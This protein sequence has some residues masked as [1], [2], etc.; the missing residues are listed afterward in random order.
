M[1]VVR[2]LGCSYQTLVFVKVT[3][4][5]RCNS[6]ADTFYVNIWCEASEI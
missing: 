1:L 3:V 6:L 4:V 2:N 5:V